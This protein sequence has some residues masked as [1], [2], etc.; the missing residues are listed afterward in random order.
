MNKQKCLFTKKG[1][2]KVKLILPQ[3]GNSRSRE[4]MRKEC[5]RVN[6]DGRNTI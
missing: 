1:N 6:M 5:R 4:D 2:R 3:V